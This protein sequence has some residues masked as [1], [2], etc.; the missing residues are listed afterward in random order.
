MTAPCKDCQARRSDC[1]GDC[2]EYLAWSRMNRQRHYEEQQAKKLR[3]IDKGTPWMRPS[4]MCRPIH[5]N[6][7]VNTYERETKDED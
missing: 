4:V 1:H 6:R 7:E 5:R 3:Y 2:E